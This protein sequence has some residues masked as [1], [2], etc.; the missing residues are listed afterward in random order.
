MLNQYDPELGQLVLGNRYSKYECPE[1]LIA[2]LEHLDNEIWR[3][4]QN[5][6]IKSNVIGLGLQPGSNNAEEYVNTVF[7]MRSY[8]WGDCVCPQGAITADCNACKPNFQ[9][10]DF[11]V[12]WYKHLGRGDTINREITPNEAITMFKQCMES[13]E[14]QEKEWMQEKGYSD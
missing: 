14:Q 3:V 11:E 4:T 1:Y 9:I 12:R 2:L 6:G 13:L 7:S 5:M 10:G 8:Y